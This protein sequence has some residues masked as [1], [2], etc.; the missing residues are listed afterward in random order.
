MKRP[1][2]GAAG[3]STRTA[4]NP[5]GKHVISHICWGKLGGT[6]D[7]RR[8]RTITAHHDQSS[9]VLGRKLDTSLKAFQVG[10]RPLRWVSSI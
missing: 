8:Q 10:S 7:H 1:G 9:D 6:S 5:T 4:Q 2:F 3:F